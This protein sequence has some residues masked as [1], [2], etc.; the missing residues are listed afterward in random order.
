MSDAEDP[1]EL[2]IAQLLNASG[3]DPRD[4]DLAGTPRR[5]AT[6]WR[7]EF[8]GAP[9]VDAAEILGEPV[10][11]EAQT[12]LVVVRDLPFHGMCPHH[13]LPFVGRATVAYAPRDKLV[14]FGRLGDLVRHC[15]RRLTL[16]ERAGND[17]VDALMEHLDAEGA[18][19]VMRAEHTCLRIPGNRHA[20]AVETA[21]FR[22]VL[23]DRPDL[24]GRL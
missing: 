22:G 1:L 3:Y 21:A 13:L 24:Q 5:V 14:G 15:T 11:G 2:A 18:G 12:D 8:M 23:R 16:Q 6:L 17:V 4:S 20:A 7:R 19:C 10:L 9:G